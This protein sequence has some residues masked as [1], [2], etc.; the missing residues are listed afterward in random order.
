MLPSR[1]IAWIAQKGTFRGLN[2]V[3]GFEE[4]E[5]DVKVAGIIIK[6]HEDRARPPKKPNST[7]ELTRL[8]SA[9]R[10]TRSASGAASRR[11]GPDGGSST[12]SFRR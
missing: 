4:V 5:V 1:E 9:S 8:R 11:R 12:S 3:G 7:R 6:A 2:V 10:L